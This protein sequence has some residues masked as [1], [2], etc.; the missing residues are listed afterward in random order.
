MVGRGVTANFVVTV[1]IRQ[2]PIVE[3]FPIHVRMGTNIT[4][5][6]IFD[7][8]GESRGMNEWTEFQEEEYGIKQVC[9][10]HILTFGAR[11]QN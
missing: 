8:S 3:F 11:G 1:A 10:N 4:T 7:A 5:L 6:N 9:S 2:L